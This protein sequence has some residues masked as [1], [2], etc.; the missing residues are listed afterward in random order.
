MASPRRGTQDESARPLYKVNTWVDPQAGGCYVCCDLG[1]KG[2]NAIFIE[3]TDGQVY[4]HPATG[5]TYAL[6]GDACTKLY[7]VTG[8]KEIQRFQTTVT[9]GKEAKGP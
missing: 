5:E 7:R 3:F 9:L 1:G 4:R 2:Q 8:L 6:A